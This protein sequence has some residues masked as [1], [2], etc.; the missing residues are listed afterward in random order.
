MS[1]K[2]KHLLTMN[3]TETTKDG[4]HQA[5]LP[6]RVVVNGLRLQLNWEELN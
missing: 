1:R 6:E 4:L 5:P 3:V 2:E